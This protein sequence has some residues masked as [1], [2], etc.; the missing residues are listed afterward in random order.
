MDRNTI[1]PI[2]YWMVNSLLMSILN[3]VQW[4][5]SSFSLFLFLIRN[6][7]GG[8]ADE[9]TGE[10]QHIP[11]LLVF[12][13]LVLDSENLMEKPLLKRYG[14]SLDFFISLSAFSSN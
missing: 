1:I 13:C 6:E 14:V 10:K 7:W 12:D 11:R 3:R 5:L 4:V 9:F 8:K 2:Q